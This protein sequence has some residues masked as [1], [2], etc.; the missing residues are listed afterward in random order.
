MQLIIK[1]GEIIATHEDHQE[2]ADKYP[3]CEC[4]LWNKTLP[5]QMP[6]APP[7]RDP[8]TEAERL[9]SYRDRRRIAYPS[10]QDQLDMMYHDKI[11]GTDTWVQAI[12]SV[13]QRFP[14]PGGETL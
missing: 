9:L 3:G 2:V 5:P 12:E 11:D 14:R 7:L 10:I 6:G 13:K 8:R 4:V 1:A